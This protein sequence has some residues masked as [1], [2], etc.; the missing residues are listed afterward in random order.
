[1]IGW[2]TINITSASENEC[3]DN[4]QFGSSPSGLT[5]YSTESVFKKAHPNLPRIDFS[6]SPVPDS[7]DQLCNEPVDSTANQVGCFLPGD[8]LSNISFQSEK[9]LNGACP[10]CLHFIGAG[11]FTNTTPMLVVYPP[12]SLEITFPGKSVHFAGMKMYYGQISIYGP[13]DTLLGTA[14]HIPTTPNLGFWGV[15]SNKQISRITIWSGSQ[16]LSEVIFGGK[17]AWPMYMPALLHH[18]QS[19]P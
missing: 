1:M 14:F 15:E 12:D 18:K 4:L 6:A 16:F 2:I 3:I 13:N 8:I 19:T 5:F 9:S 17:F 10:A 11:P 7:F